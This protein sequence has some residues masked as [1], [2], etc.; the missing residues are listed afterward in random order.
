MKNLA[1]FAPLYRLT[2]THRV[3]GV[4]VGVGGFSIQVGAAG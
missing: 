4:G 2:C 1:P 3:H